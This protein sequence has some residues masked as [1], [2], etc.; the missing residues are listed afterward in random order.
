MS[1]KKLSSLTLALA[2]TLAMTA[3]SGGSASGSTP[4]GSAP[5]ASSQAPA[6]SEAAEEY[7]SYTWSA[8]MSVADTT[9]NYMIVERFAQLVSERSGGKIIVD[10][11]HSGQLGNTTEFNQGVVAGSIQIGSGMTADIVDF[12]PQAALFDLPN[13]FPNVEVMRKVMAGDFF[14]TINEYNEKG[15]IHMLGYAD[16]GFRQLTSNKETRSLADLSGQ[17]IRVMQNPYHI[18]YWQALGANPVAMEFTEVFMGLQQGTIDGQ[19][20]PYMNI[21]GNNMQEVQK[22]IVETN[23]V[24]HIITFFMNNDLYQSLPDNVRALVDECAAEAVEYSHSQ[25]DESIAAYKQTCIDQGC[26]IVSLPA[27]ELQQFQER[28]SGVYDMVRSNL[29]DEIVDEILAEVAR[30]S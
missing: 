29:G 12:V 15:G 10:I 26:E 16:A 17:K 2:L 20:N 14:N 11:Y 19:E 28:A 25:A 1:L 21:V 13:L 18:A 8:A 30:A 3:C 6:P 24:G 27:E 9:I 4:S 7:D 5:A 23:H 22:Y